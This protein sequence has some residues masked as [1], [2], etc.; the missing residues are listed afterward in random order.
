MA[1]VLG[2]SRL[3]YRWVSSNGLMNPKQLIVPPAAL[4]A[5]AVFEV[6]AKDA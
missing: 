1:A 2:E 5:A 6:S 3:G 4:I